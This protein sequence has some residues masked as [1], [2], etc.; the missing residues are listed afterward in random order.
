V[1]SLQ[2][3]EAQRWISLVNGIG[4]GKVLLNLTFKPIKLTLPKELLGAGNTN[5]NYA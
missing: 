1:L 4:S 3:K 2:V 5:S